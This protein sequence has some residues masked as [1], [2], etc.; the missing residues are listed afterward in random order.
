[1]EENISYKLT[2]LQELELS[3]DDHVED[4]KILQDVTFS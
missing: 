3:F 1:M 4:F 2:N